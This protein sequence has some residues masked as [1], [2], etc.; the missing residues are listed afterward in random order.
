RRLEAEPLRDAI[1]AIA[2]KLELK[3]PQGSLV[4]RLGEVPAQQVMRQG[5]LDTRFYHRAVYLP[6]VRDHHIDSLSLFDFADSSLVSGERSTTTVPSQSL[7]LMNSPFVIRQ[8]E[9]AASRLRDDAPDD[10][11][12]VRLAYLR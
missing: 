7:F 11:V 10:Q 8:A 12:R 4:A 9:A 6:V 5:P 1:L 3:P 2:G